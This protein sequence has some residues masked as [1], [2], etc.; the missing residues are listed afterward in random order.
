MNNLLRLSPQY[1]I[2]HAFFLL[3]VIQA[4]GFRAIGELSCKAEDRV[5]TP[6]ISLLSSL[7]TITLCKYA[8]S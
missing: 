8:V 6:I 1:P 4:R 5:S 2:L 7:K 3:V